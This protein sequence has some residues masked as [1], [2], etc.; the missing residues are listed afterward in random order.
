MGITL[1]P[2]FTQKSYSWSAWKAVLA[3]K[4]GIPQHYDDGLV[5]TVYFY[6]G[7]EVHMCTIWKAAVP[8]TIQAYYSQS[9]NDLDKSDF[10][11]NYLPTS[12]GSLTKLSD[13]GT[14]GVATS[15]GLGGFVPDPANNPY[16]PDVDEVVGHYVDVMGALVTRG[17]QFTDEGSFRDDFADDTLDVS[18]TGNAVFTSGSLRV[19]GVGTSFISE[20]NRDNYVKLDSD[21]VDCWVRVARVPNDT[22]IILSEPYP[23]STGT[24]P[25][26]KTRWVTDPLDNGTCV[27][28]SSHIVL[29]TG[30]GSTAGV[31][32]ERSG[33]FAPLCTIWRSAISQRV[34]GCVGFLGFRDDVHNPSHY[35]D[36]VFDGTDDTYVTF[37]SAWQGDEQRSVVKLPVGLTTNSNLRYKIDLNVEYCSLEVNGVLIMKHEDHVP[38]MYAEMNLCAGAHNVGETSNTNMTIDSVLYAD[39]DQVQIANLFQAPMPIVVREDQ[40]TVV[41]TLTTTS[42]TANQHIV[43]YVVPAGKV[44]YLI[45]YRFD[46][47]GTIGASPITMGKLPLGPIPAAPGVVDGNTMRSFSLPAGGTTQCADFGSNPR[48]I[49]VG[50][51]TVVVAVTPTG[52]V[53]TTWHVALDFVLR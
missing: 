17:Q 3:Q 21:G 53:P 13:Q 26:S 29:S 37:R 40:H 25:A 28:S 24:G 52:A 38:D 48:K 49:G 14:P 45:G 50:G 1:A 32:I 9:Q 6:D 18:L 8:D 19:S 46:C 12:N 51:D 16:A 47:E 34:S 36:V 27:I 4:G 2:Q 5:Y 31:H 42:T 44:A 11:T 7:P 30:T 15:K 10:E 20:V 33:D 39:H 22:I 43:E 23:G 41:G 35:C